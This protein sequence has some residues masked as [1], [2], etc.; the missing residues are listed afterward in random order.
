ME[1]ALSPLYLLVYCSLLGLFCTESIIRKKKKW[2]S[3]E[4]S[5]N[6]TVA[7]KILEVTFC[8]SRQISVAVYFF[9][10]VNFC[11]SFVFGYGNVC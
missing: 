5:T 2:P 1:T 7:K 11:F 4:Q 8:K 6:E 3:T 10:S 9:I